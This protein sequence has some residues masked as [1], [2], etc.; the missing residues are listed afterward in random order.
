M[1][2][3]TKIT[4]QNSSNS[5]LPTFTCNLDLRVRGFLRSLMFST[6]YNLEVLEKGYLC[7]KTYITSPKIF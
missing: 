1:A 4:K 3:S 6:C 7:L 2:P 5:I